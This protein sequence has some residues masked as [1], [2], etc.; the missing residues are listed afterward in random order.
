MAWGLGKPEVGIDHKTLEGTFCADGNILDLDWLHG[1]ILLG[2]QKLF[3]C[4]LIF[5]VLLI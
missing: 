2:G 1:Y 4:A 5:G 3:N